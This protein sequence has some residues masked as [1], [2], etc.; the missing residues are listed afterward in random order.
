MMMVKQDLIIRQAQKGF[1]PISA[2]QIFLGNFLG[3]HWK[4][5]GNS[6]EILWEFFGN[7]L[8]N[9]LVMYGWGVLIWEFF[10]SFF[11]EFFGILIRILLILGNLYE[12]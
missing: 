7:S 5:I 10:G 1:R 4:F 12:F 3:I 8:G 2:I 6:L 11:W 9:S